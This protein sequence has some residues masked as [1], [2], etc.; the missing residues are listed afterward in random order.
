MRMMPRV[1]E[2]NARIRA[3]IKTNWGAIPDRHAEAFGQWLNHI[4]AFE[5]HAQDPLADYRHHQFPAEVVNVVS[6]NV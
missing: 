6:G 2:N 1:V 4:D 3:L 5:A